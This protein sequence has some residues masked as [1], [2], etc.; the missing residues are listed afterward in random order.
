[1]FC[2]NKHKFHRLY[3]L[4]NDI[5]KPYVYL[6]CGN[7]CLFVGG[8]L[9]TTPITPMAIIAVVLI[10]CRYAIRILM[11]S[12]YFWAQFTTDTKQYFTH[13]LDLLF[14]ALVNYPEQVS[15][16]WK[17]NW[18]RSKLQC[19]YKTFARWLSCVHHYYTLLL[20]WQTCRVISMSKW[21]SY[22]VLSKIIIALVCSH[23]HLQTWGVH[24]QAFFFIF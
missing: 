6:L 15:S 10:F 2:S 19:K 18:F 3:N 13:K 12:Q 11:W 8:I 1:M 20:Q 16:Q 22:S 7:T 5:S 24:C 9:F 14:G 23:N 21:Q 17:V 4:K